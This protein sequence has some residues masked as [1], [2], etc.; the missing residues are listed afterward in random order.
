MASNN[1]SPY[2]NA[3][4]IKY[5][6]GDITLERIPYDI[7]LGPDTRVHTVLEGETIQNIAYK[8]YGDSGLWGKIADANSI[9]NP[10]TEL[11]AGVE[12]IIP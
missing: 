9:Y 1:I 6:N 11:E 10:F 2:S 5:D 4:V 12:I 8:Y 3:R 7:T